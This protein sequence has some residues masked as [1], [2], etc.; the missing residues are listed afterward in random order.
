[1]G[2]EHTNGSP[3]LGQTTT[4]YNNLQKKRTCKFVDFAVPAKHKVKLKEIE[5]K[6]KYLNY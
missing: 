6:D 2:F 4:S 1:M 5:K 3:N